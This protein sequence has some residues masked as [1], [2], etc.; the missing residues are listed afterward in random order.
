VLWES[1]VA[2]NKY[3]ERATPMEARMACESGLAVVKSH[4]KREDVNEIVKELLKQY[5]SRI[6]SPPL[7]KTFRECYDVKRKKPTQEYV[8]LYE[9]IR[10]ELQDL[11]I[12]YEY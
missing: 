6:S 12:E 7:G 4:M 1:A 2:S 5:E 11:G 8:E 3:K 9:K 10:K